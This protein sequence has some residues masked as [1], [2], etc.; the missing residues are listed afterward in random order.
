[1]LT[2]VNCNG[3]HIYGQPQGAEEKNIKY[4]KY[5]IAGRRRPR[6]APPGRLCRAGQPKKKQNKI[7]FIFFFHF[8]FL[9]DRKRPRRAP[10]GRLRPA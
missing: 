5:K 4:K 7:I 9:V 2:Q 6:G 3:D 10:Q 8:S 1:L